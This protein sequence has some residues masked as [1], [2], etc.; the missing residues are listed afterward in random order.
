MTAGFLTIVDADFALDGGAMM[1]IVPR[2]LWEKAHPPDD[3]NRIALVSRF[4]VVDDRAAGRL[5]LVDCGIGRDWGPKE[6]GIYAI[7]PRGIDARSLVRAS[8]FDP[9]DVTDVVLTHLHFD[10]CAGL[11]RRDPPDGPASPA[12]PS[13]VHH[14]QAAHVEWARS[15]SVKDAGSFR[16]DHVAVLAS[17]ARLSLA[18]GDGP[19]GG[20]VSVRVASGHSPG[21][22]I[23]LVET[24]GGTHVFCGDLV[25]TWSH[26]RLPWVMAY[27]TEPVR[28]IE[29][30]RRL[31]SDA[32]DRG[33]VL[34]SEH[35][36]RDARARIRRGRSA[37][38]FDAETFSTPDDR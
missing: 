27:D 36:S 37:D 10:H 8:G 31:L 7:R 1:G 16:A 22:Q 17:D 28:T 12:F 2:P 30:K 5:W 29:E 23:V 19:L 32:A 33:W 6:T 13:A 15:P 38:S 4:A 25:P 9:D 14:V 26:V 21:M 11:V 20:A 35:D 24:T 3:R 34:V 18:G